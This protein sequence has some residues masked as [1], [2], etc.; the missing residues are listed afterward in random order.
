MGRQ[1]LITG[2]GRGKSYLA[3]VL[4]SDYASKG[5]A[6]RVVHVGSQ[7]E[8]KGLTPPLPGACLIVVSNMALK[9]AGNYQ[10]ISVCGR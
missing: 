4:S 3:S 1:I 8:V 2:N 9:L 6:H 7:H 5:V 10:T